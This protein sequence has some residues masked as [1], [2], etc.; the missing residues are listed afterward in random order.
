MKAQKFEIF[1]EKNKIIEVLQSDNLILHFKKDDGSIESKVF[2]NSYILPGFVDAHAHVYGLGLKYSTINLSD[3][4]SEIDCIKIIQKAI[5]EKKYLSQGDWI[6]AR[7]WNQENWSEKDLPNMN[8]LNQYFKNQPVY[9][10]R[11][12]G[13]AAWVNQKAL[14]IANISSNTPIPFG[15]NILKDTEN[16]IT[17]IL[18]DNAM[19]LVKKHIPDFVKEQK[20]QILQKSFEYL[21]KSGITEVHD[22][23]VYPEIAEIF[24]ELAN[25]NKLDIN[26]CLYLQAQKDEYL[27][28]TQTPFTINNLDV[29]GL[30]YYADGALGSRGAKLLEAYSDAETDGILMID[31][32]N[33]STNIIE[34]SKSNWQISTH[35][36]GDKAVRDVLNSYE[37]LRNS[38]KNTVLRIEHSQHV[39]HSDIV[40]FKELDVY[41]IVQSIHCISDAIMAEKRLGLRCNEAYPWKSLINNG[42]IISG[43]SDFPI[44]SESVIIGLDAFVNRIPFNSKNSWYSDECISIEEALNSYCYN[45]HI[46]SNNHHKRGKIEKGFEANFT[47]INNDLS[48]SSHENI[49][50]TEIIATIIQGKIKYIKE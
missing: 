15:G 27:K 45:P 20:I 14:E 31:K 28:V 50:N 29:I 4:K 9:L 11:V 39:N 36:I 16:N 37:I 38:D 5:E 22:M 34:K 32:E 26:L 41:P 42:A 35:A 44:E 47:I 48:D 13:H 17:G 24:I 2:P 1:I 43:S 10:V 40:R 8:L 46:V 49:L 7:G 6:V 21:Y 25:E 19:D 23:D 18:L 30:K 3:A 12:D 33:F